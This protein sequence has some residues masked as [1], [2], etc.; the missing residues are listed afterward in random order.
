MREYKEDLQSKKRFH[1][2]FYTPTLFAAK[3]YSYIENYL[4]KD[5]L[6]SGNYR[7]WDCACGQGNLIRAIAQKHRKYAYMST[8][9]EHDVDYCKQH[10]NTS[11]TFQYDYLNDDVDNIF[12]STSLDDN[13]WK[14]PKQLREDLQN[15]QI[16]WL[17]FINPP[18]ATSQSAG[19]NSI[20]KKNISKTKVRDYMHKASMG[21][22]SRELYVQFL[23]R[24]AKEFE[25][26]DTTLALFSKTNYFNSRNTQK[27][28]ESIFEYNFKQG[29]MFSSGNFFG[30][31]KVQDFA[32]SFVLWDMNTKQS[33]YNQSIVLDVLDCSAEKI[34][35]KHIA[36][37]DKAYFLN[38]WI[39]RKRATNIFPPLSSAIKIKTTGADIR[40]RVSDGF[41]GSLMCCGNDVIKQG[42]TAIL[43]APQACAGALSITED[44]FERSMIVHAVRRI[45][46][47]TWQNGCDQFL[48]PNKDIEEIKK[49]DETII[50]DFII[51]SL[52][53]NSNQSTSIKDVLYKGNIYQIKNN[54]FPYAISEVK[55]WNISKQSII[56]SIE[57]DRKDRFVYKYLLNKALS[58]EAST[59]LGSANKLYRYFFENID[60]FDSQK[61]R[62]DNWDIGYWQIRKALADKKLNMNMLKELK[63]YHKCLSKKLTE[64][65]Y[66]LGFLKK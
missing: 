62:I 20:S 49:I 35:E 29:F 38:N 52:F 31:S 63:S 48:I 12:N 37:V 14:L 17:I 40:D 21:E 8:L 46:K 39:E 54:F 61:F 32:V 27:F 16:K 5:F 9:Y 47:C 13:S 6:S 51:W 34:G 28:R 15:K 58:E 45:I 65:I 66:D 36:L 3:S 59:I 44:N 50:S 1:G 33:L 53:S 41:I 56:E 19:A 4:G 22:V 7:V 25:G 57:C 11:I 24:L 60:E 64:V 26:L 42:F 2:E 55:T 43:S 30:T 18:Y 10:F 23:F